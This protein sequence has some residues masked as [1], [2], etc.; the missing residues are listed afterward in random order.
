[1]RMGPAEI[2]LDKDL[3]GCLFILKADPKL[4]IVNK[5]LH[6]ELPCAFLIPEGQRVKIK[7]KPV[8]ASEDSKE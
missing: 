2:I 4:L 5:Q 7:I 8:E 3:G 6:Y 1:M